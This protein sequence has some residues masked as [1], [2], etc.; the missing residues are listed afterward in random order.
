M[1]EDKPQLAQMP[2]RSLKQ[3]IVDTMLMLL[4]VPAFIVGYVLIKITEAWYGD[5]D[6]RR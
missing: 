1:I 4:F 3:K 5:H 6:V 2:R